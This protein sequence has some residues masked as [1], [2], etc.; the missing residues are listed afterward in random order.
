MAGVD[1]RRKKSVPHNPPFLNHLHRT[2][3]DISTCPNSTLSLSLCELY[4]DL[5]ENNYTMI[6]RRVSTWLG[7]KDHQDI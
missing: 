3:T 7:G 1:Y 4:I 5:T 6:V 2:K